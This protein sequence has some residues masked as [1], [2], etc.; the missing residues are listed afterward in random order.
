MPSREHVGVPDCPAVLNPNVLTWANGPKLSLR[1]ITNGSPGVIIPPCGPQSRAAFQQ[2]V[3][4][5]TLE[6]MGNY[7]AKAMAYIAIYRQL[8]SERLVT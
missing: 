1:I 6:K 8:I 4:L 7:G 5:F 3:R 2:C